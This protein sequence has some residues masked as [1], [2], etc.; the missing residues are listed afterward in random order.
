MEPSL[1]I[2]VRDARRLEA[3]LAGPAARGSQV[4]PLLEAELLRA[5]LREPADIPPDVVTMH[6]QV[7]CV[8][9]GTGAEHRIRLVYPQ[10]AGAAPGNVSVLAP[11]GAALLGLSVGTSINWPLPGGRDTRVRVAQVLWQPEASGQ[12]E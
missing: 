10:E 8:E 2:S 11:L 7:V 4:A 5:E 3:M 12:P 6:S 9:E 1:I